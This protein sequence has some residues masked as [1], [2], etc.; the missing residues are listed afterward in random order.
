[1][2]ATASATKCQICHLWDVRVTCTKCSAAVCNIHWCDVCR[3][4]SH[5]CV[6]WKVP[7]SVYHPPANE[8]PA[9]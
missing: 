7:H 5:H 3:N 2:T 8:P 1:M 4:C 6:C 9:R